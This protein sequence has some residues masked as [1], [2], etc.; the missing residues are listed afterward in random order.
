MKGF[1]ILLVVFVLFSSCKEQ[2]KQEPVKEESIIASNYSVFGEEFSSED[3]ITSALL[4]KEFAALA[5]ADTLQTTFR[6]TV[7]EVCKAKGCWMKVAL[8]NGE[9]TMVTFRD[10]GFFVPKDMAGKQVVISGVGFIDEMS[11]EDQQHF[12]EDGGESAEAIAKII[13]PKRTYSVIADGVILEE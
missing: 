4:F 11:I 10:Y 7:T 2:K 5:S 1:N 12:A 6:G 13:E 3:A 9:E 8:E